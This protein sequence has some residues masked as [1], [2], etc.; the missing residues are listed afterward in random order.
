MD[1]RSQTGVP[2]STAKVETEYFCKQTVFREIAYRYR[3]CPAGHCSPTCHFQYENSCLVNQL[4]FVFSTNEQM[5]NYPIIPAK[6]LHVSVAFFRIIIRSFFF[7]DKPRS[8]DLAGRKKWCFCSAGVTHMFFTCSA[9]LHSHCGCGCHRRWHHSLISRCHLA[10][11]KW[12]RHKRWRM[13]RFLV[14]R[15]CEV[16]AG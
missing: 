2:L 16:I 12:Q 9:L 3:W 11:A 13:Q 8:Q 1:S 5:L 4:R 10:C 15:N 6:Y 7:N 14:G